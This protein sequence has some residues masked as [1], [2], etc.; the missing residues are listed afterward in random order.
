MMRL[1]RLKIGIQDSSGAIITITKPST[2]Y[3]LF[4]AGVK[5]K[6]SIS[7]AW[8]EHYTGRYRLQYKRAYTASDNALA[9]KWSGHARLGFNHAILL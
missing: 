3:V 7:V 5:Y 1:T 9:K 4:P 6:D 8:P 2:K